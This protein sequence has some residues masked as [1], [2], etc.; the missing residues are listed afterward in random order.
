M[1]L[2]RIFS[3]IF[4][5]TI[6]FGA[7]HSVFAAGNIDAIEKYSQYL[8][9]D[10]DSNTVNDFINWNP[11]NG[12]AT[13][14]D[15]AITGTIWGETTGWINMNPT[16]GG[17]TNSCSGI[18]GGYAWGEN[19]GWIN[20]APTTAIGPNQPKINTTT[21]AITGTVW[22]QNYGWIQLSSPDGTNSGLITTWNGC[23]GGGGG[24]R[25]MS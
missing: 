19:T 23:S 12:G 13:V 18:L 21:G 8:N 5:C 11:T 25:P 16:N 6:V 9:T 15:T 7:A 2:T 10:L 1:K 17:V 4:I 3:F 24:S 14:T 20:F 22:S